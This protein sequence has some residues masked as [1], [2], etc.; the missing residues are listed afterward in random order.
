MNIRITALSLLIGS[1]NLSFGQTVLYDKMTDSTTGILTSS[2]LAPDGTDYDTYTWDDFTFQGESTINEV[3]WRG[4]NSTNG[5]GGITGF[6]IRFYESIGGGFQPKITQRP[7]SETSLDYLKGYRV[8]GIANETPIPGTSLFEYRYTLPTSLTLPGNT[9]YWV[10]IC[11]DMDKLPFW[12][13]ATTASPL[14]DGS[15]FRFF[16]GSS[17]FHYWT[18]DTAFQLRGTTSVPEPAAIVGMGLGLGLLIRRR[19]IRRNR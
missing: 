11:A 14:G 13:L 8:N 16:T 3:R 6:T 9:K 15:C 5:P 18:G 2:W 10:K 12:G 7:E 19:S 1:A 4:G 17:Q